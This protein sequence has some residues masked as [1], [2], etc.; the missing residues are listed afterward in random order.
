MGDRMYLRH[1]FQGESVKVQGD[2]ASKV[3]ARPEGGFLGLLRGA[4][5]TAA[6]AGPVGFSASC[7]I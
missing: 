6:L 2:M 4:A 1:K 7:S 3:S 5:L